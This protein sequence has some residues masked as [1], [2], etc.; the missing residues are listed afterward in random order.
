MSSGDSSFISAIKVEVRCI[1]LSPTDGQLITTSCCASHPQIVCVS[2][3]THSG[4]IITIMVWTFS[5]A[6]RY[7]FPLGDRSSLI[8]DQ[9]IPTLSCTNFLSNNLPAWGDN[10]VTDNG[11]RMQVGWMPDGWVGAQKVDR[12]KQMFYRHSPWLTWHPGQ[13][14]TVRSCPSPPAERNEQRKATRTCLASTSRSEKPSEQSPSS[15]SHVDFTTT[16]GFP[17]VVTALTLASRVS[18]YGLNEENKNKNSAQVLSDALL[19]WR[20][21]SVRCITEGN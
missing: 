12:R 5:G 16:P 4:E 19:L 18:T 15:N 3:E 6:A 17:P 2:M 20:W 14:Q 9:G 10:G 13:T 11:K 21:L 7:G 8:S 1:K